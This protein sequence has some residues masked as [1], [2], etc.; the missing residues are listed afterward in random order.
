MNRKQRRAQTKTAPKVAPSSPTNAALIQQLFGKALQ[1]HQNGRLAEAEALYRR[2]LAADSRHA[3]AL[4]LL[5]VIG[6]QVGRNDVAVDLIGKAIDVNGTVAAYHSNRGIALKDLGRIDD[7][8]ASYDAAL[9]IRPDFAQALYN[10]GNALND[11]GRID[12][13]LASYDAALRIR[14][15]Y[16][17]ALSNRGNVLKDLGRLDDALASYD[18]A[19]RIRPDYAEALSNRGI[20]LN[21]LGRLDDALASYD[22][23]LRIRPDCAEALSNR[24]NALNGLGRIDDAL[25]SYDA[26]LRIRPDYAEAHRSL[27]LV[28]TYA[29]GDPHFLVM[30]SIYRNPVVSDGARSNICFALGKAYEDLGRYAES[31]HFYAEGNALRKSALGYSIGQD[32]ALFGALRNLFG[33]AGPPRAPSSAPS[34]VPRP[35]FIVGMPRS[36]TTLAEQILASHSQ[37]YGAGEMEAM[38][39]AILAEFN[40]DGRGYRFALAEDALAGIRRRYLA[41]LG[42]LRT[43]RPVVTDKMP[44]NFRWLGFIL[45]TIPEA[46]VVNLVRD[47]IAVCWSLFKRYFPT[48]GLAFA[49]DLADLAAYHRIYEDLMAFWRER[50]PGR[51]FD[52]DYERLTED[53]EGQTRALLDYCG[54][55]WEEA[56]LDFHR[57]ERVVRTA[58]ATQV[59]RKMYRGSS[60]AW[61]KFESYLRPLVEAFSVAAGA[62]A[63][64]EP[65]SR[66]NGPLVG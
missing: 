53:Q 52:L 39:K 40:P 8:L 20:A 56:C 30:E 63:T 3:D 22:A 31:F 15:D 21:D 17:E 36:G 64:P 50:Y 42:G 14:P 44:L 46:R 32:R 54:L 6:H 35:I 5:G 16:T 18:A 55:A 12:G 60:D 57:T 25:A 33:R 47:P 43:C 9:R 41:A 38:N 2:I 34:C 62:A 28:K 51:I 59:R 48:R 58:S 49:Y 27:S 23:A 13:A 26:A 10:R 61:K 4:H 45:E 29:D 7:A 19:L 1:H 11:L 65:P 37:V 66:E 24:G